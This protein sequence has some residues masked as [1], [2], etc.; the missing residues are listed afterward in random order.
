MEIIKSAMETEAKRSSQIA[1]VHAIG[2]M[3]AMNSGY[4][5][6]TFESLLSDPD[7]QYIKEDP[8]LMAAIID[9]FMAGTQQRS[10][11]PIRKQLFN[12]PKK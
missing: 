10:E 3:C 4:A 8:E 6:V 1:G 12:P 2:F 5:G 7:K 11:Y 9:G